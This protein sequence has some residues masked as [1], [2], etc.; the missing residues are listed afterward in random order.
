VWFHQEGTTFSI[1]LTTK[2]RR[3]IYVNHEGAT[4]TKTLQNG[5]L[6]ELRVVVVHIQ[7]LRVRRDSEKYHHKRYDALD[8][9]NHQDTTGDL[10]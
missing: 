3:L 4:D 7:E 2:A 1:W 9:V 10:R 5:S 8:L 6:R